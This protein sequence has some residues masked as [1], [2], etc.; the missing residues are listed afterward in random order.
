M[1]SFS[2][3]N[4]PSL[5]TCILG[6]LEF[7]SEKK[8]PNPVKLS[9]LTSCKTGRESKRIIVVGSGNALVTGK[10][11]FNEFDA[12]F[13]D[14]SNYLSKLKSIP[15]SS[16]REAILISASGGKHSIKIAKTL[17][18]KKIKL[19][20]L[21]NNEKAKAGKYASEIFV[22]PKQREP[23]TYNTSTYLSM[24]LGKTREN[25]QTI[26][27]ILKKINIKKDLSKYNAFYIILPERFELLREMFVT[28]F[29]ELFG[30]MIVGRVY[31]AEQTKHAKTLVESK[32][33]LFIGLGVD[34]R[35]FG[36]KNNRLNIKLPENIDYGTLMAVGYYVIGNIQEKQKPFFKSNL[37]RYCKKASKIFKEK[38]TPIVE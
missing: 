29:D 14:E 35:V 33:E 36:I 2:I 20:L 21:T 9:C 5:K 19:T 23:Y 16:I 10:I 11:L 18:S 22:F 6:A 13:A 31:T 27:R 12:V 4:I 7:L 32:K 8:L 26:Y 38:I 17:K 3:K 25:P 37:E 15:L 1:Q 24:I 34:N 28:K 30:P